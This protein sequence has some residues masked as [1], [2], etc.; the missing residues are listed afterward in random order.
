MAFAV[1]PLRTDELDD[2]LV[3]ARLGYAQFDEAAWRGELGV[4]AAHAGAGCALIARNEAGRACGLIL[5]RIVDVPDQGVMLEVARLIAFDLTDPRPIAKA[6]L[7]AAVGRARQA[8]CEAVRLIRPL[9]PSGDI[10]DLVLASGLADLH[11]V[12]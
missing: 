9:T 8:G 6:L 2:A 10:L 4:D 11:S 7:E 3:L 1:T 12:F 5:Y